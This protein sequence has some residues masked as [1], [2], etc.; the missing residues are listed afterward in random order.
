M[1]V[2]AL[3]VGAGGAPGQGRPVTLVDVAGTWDGTFTMGPRDSAIATFV[4]TAT[5][6]GTGWTLLL[7]GHTPH[8]TRVVAIAG[9]SIVTETGPYAST[10]RPGQTVTTRMILHV[11][12]D[13]MS[14]SFVAHYSSGD[15]Q[16]KIAAKRR[17]V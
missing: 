15:S 8:P 7:P 17:K 4:L 2:V 9:D 13:A 12:G 1:T 6:D 10:R 16:G 11:T 5:P 3:I 14:G